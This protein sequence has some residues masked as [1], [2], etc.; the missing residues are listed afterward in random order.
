[1]FRHIG[2]PEV[3]GGQAVDQ[4]AHRESD[5]RP[6]RIDRA[7]A[8]NRKKRLVFDP[9]D[10]TGQR[11]VEGYAEGQQDGQG[12]EIFHNTPLDAA[13]A[14]IDILWRLTARQL[15]GLRFILRS[16]FRLNL[17][18]TEDAVSSQFSVG[19]RLGAIFEGIGQGIGAGVGHF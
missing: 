7:L 10:Y 19:Q 1:M 13:L 11:G 3:A 12:A 5:Q 2:E 8:A 14:A 6:D 18:R 9:A 15:P 16:A 4:D 17:G